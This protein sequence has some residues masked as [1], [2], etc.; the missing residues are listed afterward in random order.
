MVVAA[1]VVTVGAQRVVFAVVLIGVDIEVGVVL[2]VGVWLSWSLGLRGSYAG[3]CGG[4]GHSCWC[5]N[6]MPARPSTA[7]R[8]RLVSFLACGEALPARSPCEG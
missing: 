8:R 6:Y 1:V 5:G 4:C 3:C 2:V 7:C